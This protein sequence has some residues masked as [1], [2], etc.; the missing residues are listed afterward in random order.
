[1]MKGHDDYVTVKRRILGR[2]EGNESEVAKKKSY[3]RGHGRENPNL[4]G[5]K[6]SIILG[7]R[8]DLIR[9]R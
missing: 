9:V 7:D 6:R 3:F 2:M 8:P 1:M 5:C 4:K